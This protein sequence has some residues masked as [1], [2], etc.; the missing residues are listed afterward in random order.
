MNTLIRLVV[1][2]LACFALY[3]FSNQIQRL[4]AKI[5]TLISKKVGT[6]S[7][8][9]EY[10]LQRYVFLNRRSI[11]SRVYNWINEQIISLGLKREGITP[12]GYLCFWAILCIPFTLFIWRVL[13]MSVLSIFG[14]YIVCYGVILLLTRVYVAN[15]IEK[16]EMDIMDSMD[17]IVPD[18]KNGVQN[19]IVRYQDNFAPSIRSD[20]K[21]FISNIET[22]GYSFDRAM[23]ILSDNLG[24]PF[25][26]FAQKCIFYEHLGEEDQAEIFANIV[27]QNSLKRQLR[28]D[29]TEKFASLKFAFGVSS[30]ITAVYGVFCISTDT[31]TRNFLLYTSMGKIVLVAMLL[32]VVGVLS[33]I[34]TVK[35]RVI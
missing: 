29:N 3:F 7:L 1:V 22:R 23:H 34:T 12:M 26:E 25:R 8:D 16:R 5:L 13:D 2:I 28:S 17:L 33:Y 18:I 31:F 21:A 24:L 6:F 11:V 14:L 19:S 30:I 27:E 15:S 4:S 32:T 35:A 10:S 9:K 20:F